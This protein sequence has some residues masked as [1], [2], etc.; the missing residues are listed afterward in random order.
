[1][2]LRHYLYRPAFPRGRKHSGGDNFRIT[3][4][5][6]SCAPT[7]EL[8][9]V[10][11]KWKTTTGISQVRTAEMNDGRAEYTLSGQRARKDYRG[12]VVSKGRKVLRK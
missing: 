4:I 5:A 1:M 2:D 8:K 7:W 10:E 11:V 6:A 9:N 3:S 12:I